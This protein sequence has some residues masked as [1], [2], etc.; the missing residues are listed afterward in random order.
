[1]H[2]VRESEDLQFSTGGTGVDASLEGVGRNATGEIAI[3]G[4]DGGTLDVI[5]EDEVDDAGDGVGTVDGG[6]AVLEDFDPREGIDGD[7]VEI[8]ELDGAERRGAATLSKRRG[9]EAAA[10]EKD[11]RGIGAEAAE[12]DGGG[13]GRGRV[14]AVFT[15]AVGTGLGDFFDERVE[16]AGAGL[17]DLGRGDDAEIGP[18]ERLAGA[19]IRAGDGEGFEL[20]GFGGRRSL[21]ER[22]RGERSGD[23]EGAE[24]VVHGWLVGQTKR[25]RGK[26]KRAER[27]MEIMDARGRGAR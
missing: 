25:E 8:D 23:E 13:A 16:G 3:V 1:M 15:E 21:G 11:E 9:G 5:L 24:D 2:E 19:E 12:R 4:A 20:N 26:V 27:Q 6:G 18:T 10:V 22:E 7:H 17:F 14:D